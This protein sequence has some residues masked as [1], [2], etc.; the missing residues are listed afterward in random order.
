M[1]S[2]QV[3]NN[4]HVQMH[5]QMID[6]VQQQF[7]LHLPAILLCPCLSSLGLADAKHV[8][9]PKDLILRHE[10]WHIDREIVLKKLFRLAFS[11]H[12]L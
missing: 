2:N 12:G 7:T 10:L 6:N 3:E 9:W 11:L 8:A 5:I 4:C 1:S